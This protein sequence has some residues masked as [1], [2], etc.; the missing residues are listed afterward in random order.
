[1]APK[2]RR[3]PGRTTS[4]EGCREQQP[5]P[6]APRAADAAPAPQAASH[7]DAE[8]LDT[9]CAKGVELQLSGQLDRAGEIY[10]AILQ[11][12][13]DHA[14]ANYC[15]G[16]L[17]IHSQRPAEGLP[18]LKAALQAQVGVTDYWLG[19]LEALL[20]IGQTNTARNILALGR[21]QGIEGAAVEDF[22]RR[23][24]AQKV[25]P[26]NAGRVFMVVAPPYEHRSAGIRVL[27]TLCNELNLCGHTA[28][29]ILFRF[30]PD[31]SAVDFH[32]PAGDAGYCNELDAIPR[33]PA[34]DDMATLRALIDGAYVVYPEVLQGNPLNARRIVRYVLNRPASN[35]YPRLEGRSDFIVSFSRQFWPAPHWNAPLFIDDPRFN[36]CDTAPA[37]ERTLDCTYFG[38]GATFGA[39]IKVPGSIYMDKNWPT[40]KEGLAALLRH[41]RYFFTWDV[42]TQTNI[43]A[44]LC[45][46]IPVVM[47]W[48]PFTPSIL[49][50]E[51]G[52]VPYAEAHMDGGN[53]RDAKAIVTFDPAE[54]ESTRVP[55]IESYRAAAGGRRR[56]VAELA[57]AVERHFA[58]ESSVVRSTAA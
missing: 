16:M 22:A 2:L 54:F 24:G 9:A 49:Q 25:P 10:G 48:A 13:P 47:R 11:S 19:Y 58:Q 44:L 20:L 38:K 7:A 36:D 46:A 32:T 21:R 12:A 4:T 37:V 1:M 39:C 43:D 27:H 18:Y 42:V 33:L 6:A 14:A 53:A 55:F 35:G 31:G 50:T 30:R 45:G 52:M 57:A 29:L 56:T 23:L 34:S 41:T 3:K 17:H 26:T 28:H 40:D 5:H 15:M 8:K 51:F